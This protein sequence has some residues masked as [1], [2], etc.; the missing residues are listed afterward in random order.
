MVLPS[1]TLF[2]HALLPLFIF[3]PRYRK[4]LAWA[5]EHHRMFCIALIKPDVTD[6]QSTDD[7]FHIAGLGLIRACVGHEDGSSHLVLQGIARVEFT[8]FVREKPF[9]MARLR[10]VPSEPASEE[11]GEVLS[12]QVLEFCAHY[13][14]KGTL[15]PETLDQQLANVND[16]AALCDIVA[17]TFVRDP[18]RRQNMLEMRRVA[19][20]LR[21]LIQH[22]GDEMP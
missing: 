7:F 22:L 18:M 15:I 19:D 21:A 6:A 11:E 8:E 10:E 3:E 5:L 17:H 4:M 13:Q 12:A 9:P 16:P 14:A 2:P 20:R 1:A